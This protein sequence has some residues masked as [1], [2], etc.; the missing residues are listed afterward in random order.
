MNLKSNSGYS[1]IEIG[2]ALIIVAIFMT[3]SITLL[4]ASN[5]NYSDMSSRS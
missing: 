4:S 1:L 5:E 3:A 2:I